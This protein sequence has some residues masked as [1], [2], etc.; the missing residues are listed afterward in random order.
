MSFTVVSKR[1]FWKMPKS[2]LVFGF[3]INSLHGGGAER[4]ILN[5]CQALNEQ[6]ARVVL[7]VLEDK[8]ICY[9]LKACNFDVYFLKRIPRPIGYLYL[10][11][12]LQI[13]FLLRKLNLEFDC[14]VSNL[15][16][17]DVASRFLPITNKYCLIHNN[18]SA[19]VSLE[20]VS[21]KMLF[22][23]LM[24]RLAYI[25]FAR[26]AYAG[27]N[28]IYL[29][30]DSAKKASLPYLRPKRKIL[31][32]NCFDFERIRELGE[33]YAVS[34]KPYIIHVGRFDRQKN[35][36]LLITAFSQAKVSGNLM[37]LGDC[38]N[39]FG[40]EVK[41]QVRDLGLENRVTFKDFVENPY[42]YIKNAEVL[43]LSSNFEGLST[44]L[45][46]AIALGVKVVSTDCDF[47]PREI[48]TGKLAKWLCPVGDVSALSRKIEKAWISR[49]MP[50]KACIE[51]FDKLAIVEN[52]IKLAQNGPD[53]I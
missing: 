5:L 16:M 3:S 38:N 4:V 29:T 18:I 6:G 9:D 49:E 2:N 53:A 41:K 45:I 33:A 10:L 13:A 1:K 35:H 44:V 32:P 39:L 17:S 46:E 52:Y 27:Q 20:S 11:K 40:L 15:L 51:R 31:I 7:I 12:Y 48:M 14:F 22:P 43:V 8:P 26:I 50:D 34:E 36:Q 28:L 21:C 25:F 19:S 23:V 37:L 24:R 42:P 30:S 47:G